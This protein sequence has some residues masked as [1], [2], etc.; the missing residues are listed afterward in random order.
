MSAAIAAG[1]VVGVVGAGASYAA[2]ENAAN[3]A[4]N[5]ARDGQESAE[6]SAQA[7]LDFNR[8]Q[9]ETQM[10]EV[11][12]LESMFGPIRENLNN[13]YQDM[14]VEQYELR[15]KEQLEKQ[16]QQSS[17]NLDKVF[18]NNGMYNSGQM[19]SAN[20]ALEVAREESLGANKLNAENQYNQQQLQWLGMGLQEKSAAQGLATQ[21][22]QGMN[23]AFGNQSNIAM[24]GG[25]NQ[26]NISMQQSQG[27]SQ[28][29][30]GMLQLGGYAAGG[31]FGSFGGQTT[32]DNGSQSFSPTAADFNKPGS[33]YWN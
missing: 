7:Q 27:Y 15:G 17:E 22:S 3:S 25:T 18:S 1:V 23:S 10:A 33:D 11:D 32:L 5:S 28:L 12:A 16:Y 21:Y 9:W 13:Y 6:R 4:A 19:A 20:V 29:G 24:Q 14:S 26:S 31:G 8:E 2:S 30:N